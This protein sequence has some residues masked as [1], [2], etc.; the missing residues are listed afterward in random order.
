MSCS[1][2]FHVSH[3]ISCRLP[4]PVSPLSNIR[5][6]MHSRSPL[7]RRVK[8]SFSGKVLLPHPKPPSLLLSPHF[9]KCTKYDSWTQRKNPGR[10]RGRER[11]G[12]SI[13]GFR[14][15]SR[16][17]EKKAALRGWGYIPLVQFKKKKK[18]RNC[19]SLIVLRS[20][21]PL[22]YLE[23]VHWARPPSFSSFIKKRSNLQ[24][25]AS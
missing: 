10:E 5:N 15:P 2:N 22:H 3:T 24:R 8:L 23:G 19:S 7:R 16:E 11:R 20:V 25:C 21:G 13:M 4:S 18:R 9:P 14:T 17:R 12:N 1:L 6:Y